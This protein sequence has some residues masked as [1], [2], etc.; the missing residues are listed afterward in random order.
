M[1]IDL[2]EAEVGVLEKDGA[3]DL[4]DARHEYFSRYRKV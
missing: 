1:E 2:P 3:R 4:L